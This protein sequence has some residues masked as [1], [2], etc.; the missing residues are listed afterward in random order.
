MEAAVGKRSGVVVIYME[1]HSNKNLTAC[2]N[3]LRA[4]VITE[5]EP[6]NKSSIQFKRMTKGP[7]MDVLCSS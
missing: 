1:D 5:N 2:R 7:R 3:Y 4:S 6:W